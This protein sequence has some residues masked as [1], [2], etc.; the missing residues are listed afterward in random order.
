ML[1]SCCMKTFIKGPLPDTARNLLRRLGY[2]EI[3]GKGQQISYARRLSG[4][5]YPRYHAYVED[6]DGGIQI[7][8]HIDQKKASYAGST[9]H[10]GEYEGPLVEQEMERM[11]HSIASLS[12]TQPAARATPQVTTPKTTAAPEKK[13]SSF[14]D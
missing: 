11:Q 1:Q 7:N 3:I 10:S 2:G 8:L 12:N 4:D 5:H 9:A 13:K 14:W 6:R